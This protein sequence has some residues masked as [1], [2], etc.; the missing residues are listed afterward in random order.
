M[1]LYA[2]RVGLDLKDSA[3]YE[4]SPPGGAVLFAQGHV[5]MAST[6]EMAFLS[7]LAK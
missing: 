5:E 2:Y 4:T 6:P 7:K 1:G 3:S